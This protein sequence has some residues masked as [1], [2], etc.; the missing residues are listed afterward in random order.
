M[1]KETLKWRSISAD[2][3]LKTS[4]DILEVIA[5]ADWTVR[6]LKDN[7]VQ[8]GIDQIGTLKSFEKQKGSVKINLKLMN[9]DPKQKGSNVHAVTLSRKNGLSLG[10]P[11]F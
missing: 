7:I 4:M 2:V 9:K 5:S 3:L 10:L 11:I 6:I 1:N 8:L